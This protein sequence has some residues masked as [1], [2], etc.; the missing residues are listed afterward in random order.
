MKLDA[1]FFNT[2]ANIFDNLSAGWFGAAFI[3]PAFSGRPAEFNFP[4]LIT[5]LVFGTV[6]FVVAYTVRK[7]EGRK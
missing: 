7:R 6:C 2:L 4:I 3:V 5:D 1:V